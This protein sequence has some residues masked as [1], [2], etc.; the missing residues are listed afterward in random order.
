[1]KEMPEIKPGMVIHYPDL[2]SDNNYGIVIK[3]NDG[4]SVYCYEYTENPDQELILVGA[5]YVVYDDIDAIYEKVDAPLLQSSDLY[6]ITTGHGKNFRVWKRSNVREMTVEEIERELGYKIKV[7]GERRKKTPEAGEKAIIKYID[8]RGRASYLLVEETGRGGYGG[9]RLGDYGGLHVTLGEY[10]PV[11]PEQ[12]VGIYGRKMPGGSDQEFGVMSYLD[13]ENLVVH[14]RVS[15]DLV[16]WDP[17]RVREMT[18]DEIS[19]ALG[20][21][22]KVVK[23]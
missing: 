6:D 14:D 2:V 20:Y 18:V 16:V 10:T 22:V 8:A 15:P 12:V 21:E 11:A 9:H 7:I 23:G 17:E 5:Q 4:A 3:V 19:K 13:I 1:M